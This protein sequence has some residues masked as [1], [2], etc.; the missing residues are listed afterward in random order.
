MGWVKAI[1]EVL[2]ERVNTAFPRR[3]EITIYSKYAC[4]N[5]EFK[6]QT[7]YWGNVLANFDTTRKTQGKRVCPRVRHYWVYHEISHDMSGRIMRFHKASLIYV[8]KRHETP[9]KLS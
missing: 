4:I 9:Q 7:R 1:G 3:E 5:W 8:M 6:W 2:P